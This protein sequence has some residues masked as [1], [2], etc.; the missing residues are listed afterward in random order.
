MTTN[1]THIFNDNIDMFDTTET[2]SIAEQVAAELAEL[3]ERDAEQEAWEAEQ[4]WERSMY[5]ELHEI[6]HEMDEIVK[7]CGVYGAEQWAELAAYYSDIHKDLYGFRPHDIGLRY[8]GT[9]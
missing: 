7:R 8:H 6:L 2:M 9:R 1:Y 3:A 4:E 5:T